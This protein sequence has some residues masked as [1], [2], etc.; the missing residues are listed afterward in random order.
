M[1]L[2]IAVLVFLAFSSGEADC[3]VACVAGPLRILE[4]IHVGIGGELLF[5]SVLD[6]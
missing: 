4:S 3:R 2:I 1:V 5:G 6:F